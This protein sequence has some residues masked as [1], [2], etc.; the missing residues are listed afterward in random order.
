MVL[1]I[2]Y[3]LLLKSKKLANENNSIEWHVTLYAMKL[4]A[5][6]NCSR[7]RFWRGKIYAIEARNIEQKQNNR[8]DFQQLVV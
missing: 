8:F 1:K 6:R 3:S 7:C 2:S 4:T 5:L